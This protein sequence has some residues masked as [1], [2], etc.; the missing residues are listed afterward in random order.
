MEEYEIYNVD[1]GIGKGHEQSYPRPAIIIKG[2]ENV[3]MY[4]VI[5]L[6]S[7]LSHLNLPHTMQ[8]NRTDSTNLKEN[9]VA[10]LFQIRSIDKSRITLSKI[11]RLGDCEVNKIKSNLKNLFSL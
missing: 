1:F 3:G 11:G 4:V 10:L 6:T 2:I 9:S 5:P 8:I 7:N